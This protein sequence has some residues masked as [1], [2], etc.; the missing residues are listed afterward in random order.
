MGF[1]GCLHSQLVIGGVLGLLVLVQCEGDSSMFSD[2]RFTTEPSDVIVNR[3]EA[4]IFN[5]GV[6]CSTTTP[7]VRWLKDG[8]PVNMDSGRYTIKANGSLLITSVQHSRTAPRISDKGVYQCIA[9]VENVGQIVSRKAQLD[10]AHLSKTFDIQPHDMTLYLSDVAMFRCEID[11]APPPNITWF[12]DG[13]PLQ[14]R[15]NIRI[16]TD[17]VL[18]INPVEFRD[19]GSYH[20]VAENLDKI[21]ARSSRTARLRQNA[22]IDEILQG[23]QPSFVMRPKNTWAEVGTTVILFCGANGQAKEGRQPTISWLK[24]G[25]TIDFTQTQGRLT[26][27]GAGSLQIYQV[28]EEDSGT[29][30]CRAENPIDSE[31]ADAT[32]TVQVP[33]MFRDQPVNHVAQVNSDALFLCD[34]YGV[35]MPETR[36]LKNGQLVK[37]L[38][39]SDYFQIV[40]NKHLRILGLL[41][42]DEGIYQCFGENSLGSIQRSAQLLVVDLMVSP[43]TPSSFTRPIHHLGGIY[44]DQTRLPSEPRE[45]RAAI[46]SRRF[47]TL[48]WSRPRSTGEGGEITQLI[49]S[50]YWKELGS[51]RERVMN[52]TQLGANIQHLKPNTAYEFRLRT[53]NDYG[54]SPTFARISITTE[55]DVDVPSPP[56]NVEVTALSSM[57]IHIQWDPPVQAKG[58]ITKYVVISYEV[59]KDSGENRVEVLATSYLLEN[60]K[61]F[62]EYSFRVFASNEIGDGTSSKEYTCRTFSAKPSDT[63]KNVS[64]E[65]SSSESI[66]VRWE[67]PPADSQNGVITGYKIKFK[68][69]GDSRPAK[70][71]TTDGNRRLYALTDLMKDT[72]YQV[73]ISALTVNGSGPYVRWHRATTYRDDLDETRV[74]PPPRLIRVVPY[75]TSIRVS[76][77]APDPESKILVRGYI[78][79]YGKGVPD[80]FRLTLDADNHVYTIEN[81]QPASL[82][83]MTVLAFNNIGDGEPKY[84]TALTSE[85]T[86]TE[87]V[88]PMMPPVG[89][90]AIVLSSSTVVLTWADTSLGKSQTV[91]DSRYYTVRYTSLPNNN[92]RYK[93]LNSTD[94]N[95]HIDNLK[96]NTRYEFSVKVIKGRRQSTWSMSEIN[97]TQESAPSSVPRDLTPVPKEDNPTAVTMNWQPPQKPNGQ[98]TGYLLFYTTDQSQSD[99][100]WVVEGVLGEKLSTTVKGLTPDTTYYFKIQARNSKGYGPMSSTIIYKTPAKDGTGGGKISPDFIAPEINYNPNGKDIDEQPQ[101]DDNKQND[102]GGLSTNVVIIIVTCVVGASFCIVIIVVAIVLCQKRDNGERNKRPQAA[103]QQSPS[104]GK[105]AQR[106]LKKP[107]LWI[108]HQ[109][110]F[111]L[112]NVD[113]PERSE[114]M[115]TMSTLR[116]NSVDGNKSIDDLPPYH[117]DIDKEYPEIT[118]H[119]HGNHEDRYTPM[120]QQPMQH[121]P[122]GLIRPKATKPPMM[123]GVDTQQPSHR[124]PIAMVT[125]LQS[126]QMGQM[127]SPHGM[128]PHSRPGFPRTQYNM[129][130]TTSPRVNTDHSHNMHGMPM[131]HNY[132]VSALDDDESS[133]NDPLLDES[134]NARVGYGLMSPD[135]CPK[136]SHSLPHLAGH[137]INPNGGSGSHP[138]PPGVLSHTPHKGQPTAIISPDQQLPGE[139]EE[140]KSLPRSL[141]RHPLR[142]FSVP[143]PPPPGSNPLSSVALTPK[144]QIVKPQQTSSPYK[145][146]TPPISSVPIKPRTTMP[147]ISTPKAPDVVLKGTQE[148]PDLQKSVSTEELTAEMANLDCLM[149]DLNAITQQDFEC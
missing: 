118:Y 89:L 78:L 74:P 70:T 93:T 42:K 94:L 99:R 18:E 57:S 80:S 30:T 130:Y 21:K 73:R 98:I 114:S 32:L 82:Y 107:D 16:F 91:T 79:G 62:Q 1:N 147:I 52:T 148:D 101:E 58:T 112:K 109:Q 133:V 47:V 19:F 108:D 136:Q 72:E 9:S 125:A 4:A 96:P 38:N 81:L 100:E 11:G 59:G 17:G 116:R 106:D 45:M 126:S 46:V 26:V 102:A 48:S 27:V 131:D 137:G 139:C 110:Q 50:V 144:H 90:K 105:M 146:P 92:K 124:E 149:K 111:E 53:Y 61:S 51:E 10:I 44:G 49:Y 33:P 77:S 69:R 3:G 31:D 84:Q 66:I 8:K 41:K 29:F 23:I 83:V 14:D 97:I 142:S 103:Q 40:D 63:P 75:D 104:K 76:W 37:E 2:V 7:A 35:P 12:K 65:T 64:V 87:Q 86:V 15:N 39:E 115:L 127:D 22:D 6:Q 36:W 34:I 60:L 141:H 24:N 56:T 54:P 129:P 20:C 95:A 71:V 88:T 117:P 128:M 113:K 132:H 138:L 123:I 119:P 122:P 5:C 145:K 43:P 120:R 28:R 55:K 140:H 143:S 85:E 121:P 13:N 134:Y 68:K 25:I 135:I 67:P